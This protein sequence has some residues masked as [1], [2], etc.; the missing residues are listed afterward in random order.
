LWGVKARAIAK[1]WEG[2]QDNYG[3]EIDNERT[4]TLITDERGSDGES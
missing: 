2:D 4:I 3:S 1:W